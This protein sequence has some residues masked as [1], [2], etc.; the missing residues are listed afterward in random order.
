MAGL[1]IFYFT[2]Y[3]FFHMNFFLGLLVSAVAVLFAGW[4]VPGVLVDNFWTA[5]VVAAVLSFLNAIVKPVLIVL[6]LPVTVLTLGLFLL[7][8]N[9][10]I[11]YAASSLVDGFR[12]DGFWAALFFSLVVSGSRA[13]LEMFVKKED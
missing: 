6:T 13:V 7:V 5:L 12:V 9:V 2:F 3:I 11:V 4:L 8:I 10:F 1:P